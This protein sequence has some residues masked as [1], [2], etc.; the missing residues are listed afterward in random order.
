MDGYVWALVIVSFIILFVLT[1]WLLIAFFQEKKKLQD[2]P[3]ILNF[4]SSLDNGYFLGTQISM[5]D[6]K[7]GRHII[8]YDPKDIDVLSD[9]KS[10]L[11]PADV[12]V[13]KNKLFSLPKGSVSRKRNV[14]VALPKHADD[15]PE[16]LKNSLIGKGLMWATE[17]QN[18]INAEINSLKEGHDRKDN[19][20]KQLGN[21]EASQAFITFQQ[22][23]FKD[24]LK[25][26]LEAK[27]RDN[28]SSTV[29][30]AGAL[31]SQQH[32]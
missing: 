22:E 17:A 10:Q 8:K 32:G 3:L 9:D 5:E 12:I 11:E 26:T 18:A 29:L 27:G 7:N 13:E 4:L 14:L 2:N 16:A 31:S 19:I 1:L 20:L 28:K 6:G 23:L 15:F 25:M 21:G 30:N 24:A